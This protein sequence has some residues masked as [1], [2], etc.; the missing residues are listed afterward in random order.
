[1]YRQLLLFISS[2]LFATEL[3]AAELNNQTPRPHNR[4]VDADGKPLPVPEEFK[5]AL[6]Y[7]AVEARTPVI[8][9]GDH[10][11]SRASKTKTTPTVA[12]DA[13]CRWLHNRITDLQRRLES[14]SHIDAYLEA[15]LSQHQQQWSCLKCASTG[16][17]SADLS[18]CR[19]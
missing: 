12:N 8:S 15:E 18:R 5:A 10:K 17:S 13:S 14:S 11:K 4:A 1:M 6:E 7:R 2:A 19:R 3:S 9:S 16:P